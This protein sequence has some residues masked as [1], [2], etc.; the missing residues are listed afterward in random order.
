LPTH[1]QLVPIREAVYEPLVIMIMIM[2]VMVM[3]MVM[4]MAMAVPS[5]MIKR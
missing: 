1:Q 2:M 4:A 5:I 3:V